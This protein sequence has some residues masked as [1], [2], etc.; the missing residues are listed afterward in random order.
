[1]TIWRA[2]I[3]A[4][5]AAGAAVLGSC[6]RGGPVGPPPRA[7]D[8]IAVPPQESVIAVPVT[9]DLKGLAAA[10]EAEVPRTLHSINKPGQVCVASK[11][12]KVA[13]VK[14]KT[15][16]L[17]CDIAGTVTRGPLRFVGKGQDIFVTFPVHAVVH[18]KD[19]GGVLKQETATADATASARMRIALD[20]NWNPVGT[21][22]LDYQWTNAP[23]L[24]FLGKRIEFRDPADRALKKVVARLE[25]RI[26]AEL[27]KLR[28]RA[29]IEK[30]WAKAFTS[31]ELNKANPPV[32]MRVTPNRLQYGG[33]SLTGTR[34]SLKLGMKARTETFVGD[35]PAN[36]PA[37]PLPPLE[38]LD[39]KPGRLVF[40][41]PVIADYKQLEPVVK[42]ALM[43]RQARPFPVPGIGPVMAQ[44][45]DVEI[46]GTTGGKIAAGVTFSVNA[47]DRKYGKAQG[48]VWLTGVPVN[49]PGSRKV[50]FE[51]IS[52]RGDTSRKGV[53]LL[54]RLA[55]SPAFSQTVATALAQNFE[56]DFGELMGKVTRA[57]AEKR[58]GDLLIRASI[59]EVSN[60]SLK[61]A[62]QGLYLPVWGKGTASITL[63]AP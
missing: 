51:D 23:H 9:A 60:G 22:D 49:Q 29:G 20:R 35:R 46:Y 34:L 19:I 59:D 58:E 53:D 31:L 45:G 32:W 15:P 55:N 11:K 44:F 52:V 54:L 13:F 36:P 18:A 50:A 16:T 39:A 37:T 25:R 47:Q 8:T 14:L 42:K 62:G 7:T 33:Y 1:M 3:L 43:K 12:V 40:F 48:K 61:A 2:G 4:G 28:L 17:K 10:L 63:N 41:I 38:P 27:D 5:A 21:V 24:D 30:L 56:K 26:P 6:S 57:I